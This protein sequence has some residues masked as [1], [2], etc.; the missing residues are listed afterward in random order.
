MT[1]Y[2]H[3]NFISRRETFRENLVKFR[4]DDVKLHDITSF[5]DI[6]RNYDVITY[7]RMLKS[8][9]KCIFMIFFIRPYKGVSELVL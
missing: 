8:A 5:S 4:Q 7:A 6:C 9:K 2:L 1:S 3:H